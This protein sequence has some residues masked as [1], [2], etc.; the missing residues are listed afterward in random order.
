MLT[1]DLVF[2]ARSVK[3]SQM[4]IDLIHGEEIAVVAIYILFDMA[5]G[6]GMH[7]SF[8]GLLGGVVIL[9]R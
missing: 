9:W 6:K 2:A 7:I 1:G 4:M 5:I 3:T 8:A